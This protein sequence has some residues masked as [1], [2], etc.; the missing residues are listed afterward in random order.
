MRIIRPPAAETPIVR[1]CEMALMSKSIPLDPELDAL[2]KKS[3]KY[4]MTPAE[5]W[6]QRV[7][8]AF[9]QLMDCSPNTTREQVIARATE[10]Y[11]PRPDDKAIEA[12]Q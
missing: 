9:G 5:I 2:L 12:T 3:A 10:T 7:S 4:V 8:F 11:G 1:M 6:D